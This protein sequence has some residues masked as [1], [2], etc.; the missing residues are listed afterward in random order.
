MERDD[1]AA[2]T[3]KANLARELKRL[4]ESNEKLAKQQDAARERAIKRVMKNASKM[5]E[6]VGGWVRRRAA[7]E[8]GRN[9]S[10]S[11]SRTLTLRHTPSLLHPTLPYPTLTLPYPYMLQR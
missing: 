4:R 10:A 7:A 11:A 6:K 3:A 2:S 5:F 1:H 9:T 8:W